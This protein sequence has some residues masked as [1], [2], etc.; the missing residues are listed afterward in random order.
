MDKFPIVNSNYTLKECMMVID[1]H[2]KNISF[3]LENGILVGVVT[4]GDIRRA[5]LNN[6]SLEDAVHSVMN[7]QFVSFPVKTESK[8]I[9]ERFSKRIRHIPLLDDEGSLVDVA[10]PRGNFRISVL[11]PSLKGN[12]LDYVTDCIESNW[13][14]SQGKFVTQFEKVFEEFHPGTHALAVSNGTVALH[15]AMVALGVEPGD[16]VIVPNLTFAASA[17][18]VIHAGANPVFCEID[19]STWCIDPNEVKELIGP[20]TKAI[21]PV[22]LYGQPCDMKALRDICDEYDLLMIEDSAEAVGSEWKSKKIGT[23]GDAATFSFFG[24]KTISTGEGGMIVFR[25]D[26]F[27]EKARVLRDHGMSK[28]KRYWHENVGYNYR[29]T[30]LQAAIGVAQMERLQCILDKKFAIFNKYN[31]LLQDVDGI[32]KLP[33]KVTDTLHSNWLYGIIINSDISRDGLCEELLAHGIE[34]RPFFYPLHCMPPYKHFKRSR[35][36]KFSENISQNGLSLP[37]SVDLTDENLLTITNC[38]RQ[39]LENKTE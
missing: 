30:N 12:E 18:A 11:E 23:F 39:K 28:Q 36:L 16:E 5:L 34:T 10:D 1:R 15:L 13:I 8:T 27:A 19:S 24:N 14:S 35:S 31:S 33:L 6:S 2:A 32:E 4:D 25:D 37:T 7:R 22:H 38:L 20:K 3:V 17:N 26:L 21:M 29:L 9:R